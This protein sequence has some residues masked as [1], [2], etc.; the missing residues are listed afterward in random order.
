[1]KKKVLGLVMAALT[2]STIG[3]FAA[4]Q[5]PEGQQTRTEQVAR[6][7]K[8]DKKDRKAK[9]KKERRDKKHRMGNPF[10]G[11]QVTAEQQQQLDAL[12]AERK[13]KREADKKAQK[14][15]KAQ[16]RQQFEAR[17]AQILTPEQFAQYKANCDSMKVKRPQAGRKVERGGKRK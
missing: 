15:A 8:K 5:S 17:V 11:I 7:E 3:A 1:M 2:I 16:E 14:E 9:H 13:A 4:P 10:E 12:K 6:G